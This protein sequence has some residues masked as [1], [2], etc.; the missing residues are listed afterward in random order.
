MDRARGEYLHLLRDTHHGF[1]QIVNNRRDLSYLAAFTG[2]S[3]SDCRTS[4]GG[5]RTAA[6]NPKC[7]LKERRGLAAAESV[8]RP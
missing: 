3:Q 7:L 4:C 6:H 1:R 5:S 2:S 8:K